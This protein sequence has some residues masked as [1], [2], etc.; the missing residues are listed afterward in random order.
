MRPDTK[1]TSGQGRQHRVSAAKLD[2]LIEEAVVDC[3]S[4]SEE[5]GG[6]Y[7]M[8]EDNLDL[9]FQTDVLGVRVTVERIDLTDAEE[10]VAICTREQA[11]Q[12]I[13]LLEL[14]LPV[15]PPRGAEWIE[16]F[17]RWARGGR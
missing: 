2:K 3:Y 12:V 15:P 17:R 1:K 7:T 14:P 13:S 8:L 11:R 5:I 16:A 9:P 10:I 6:F 4:E